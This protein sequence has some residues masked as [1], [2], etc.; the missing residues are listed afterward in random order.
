MRLL[1]LC[2]GILLVQLSLANVAHAE[3]EPFSTMLPIECGL[4]TNLLEGIKERYEEEV[5]MMSAGKTATGDE[6][7]HSLW[8][9]YGTKTWTFLAVNKDKG[10]T[11]VIASGDN[12]V[13]FFPNGI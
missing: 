2:L 1:K 12:L 13:M 9:N 7:F 10:V 6:L 5:V 8:I 11:C 3:V 4:T